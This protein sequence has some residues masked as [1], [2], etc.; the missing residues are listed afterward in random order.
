MLSLSSRG[1]VAHFDMHVYD[2]PD[3]LSLSTSA[4]VCWWANVIAA[5]TLGYQ[6]GCGALRDDPLGRAD[7]L[8]DGRRRARCVEVS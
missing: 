6:C 2:E 4:C 5:S 7:R 8:R 1:D 3:R